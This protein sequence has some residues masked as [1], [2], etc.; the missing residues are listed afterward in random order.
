MQFSQALKGYCHKKVLLFFILGLSCGV[1]LNLIGNTLA[2]WTTEKGIDLKIIGLFSMMMLPYSFK[3][4]WAPFIDRVRLPFS[5]KIG[6]K[7]IWGLLFQ[8]GLMLSILCLSFFKPDAQITTLFFFALLAAFFAAS[9]D[10]VVDALRI[11]T[12]EGDALKEGSSLYQFG[13]RTG[14]LLSGAGLIAL[15]N[16]I[17]WGQCYRLA[18]LLIAMGVIALLLVEEP[19]FKSSRSLTL[20]EL[21]LSPLT[22]FMHRHQLWLQLIIF[23][24]LY[25]ICNAVLGRMAYPFYTQ[26][27][28]SKNEI[29]LI[30]GAIGPWITIAGVFLGG[31]FMLR[32]GYFKSLFYLGFFEILTSVAYAVLAHLGNNVYAFFGVILFDNIIGGMGGA[33][34]VGF[35]SSLCAR[36]YSATQYALLTS[37]T[38]IAVSFIASISGYLASSLGW[39]AFFLLTGVL[40]LPALFLL[41][42]MMKV[43]DEKS[44]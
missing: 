27:G 11:D 3:F 41:H 15:S 17:E 44:A 34:F 32:F 36:A 22:D 14:M 35:L 43:S 6:H 12:L 28:F 8:A 24:V 33:V 19:S 4:L 20:K 2:L 39:I 38:M 7:K 10:I 25:K 9:Q 16:V 13:Y 1:P 5:R 18:A 37:V 40:M 26:I 42:Y 30:S 29:A 21:I 23:I 31:L